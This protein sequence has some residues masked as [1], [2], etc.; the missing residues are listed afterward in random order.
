MPG[1]STAKGKA[2]RQTIADFIANSLA[3][4]LDQHPLFADWRAWCLGVFPQYFK[5]NFG[6]RHNEFWAH[7]ELIG[8]VPD[9]PAVVALW[10][11][12][13][14]KSTT[15]EGAVIRIGSKRARRY[16]WYVSGTQDQADKHVSTISGMLEAKTVELYYP[17]LSKRLLDKYG[18]SEGWARNILRCSTGFTVE[19][20]GLDKAVRGG[21]IDWARPDLIIFDDVDGRHDTAK[22]VEKK[23]QTITESILPAGSADVAVVFVQNLIHRDS[24]ASRLAGLG[25][26]PADFLLR[27]V[28]LGPYPAVDGLDTE[29]TPDG[30]RIIAGTPTW[31]GQSLATCE[32]QIND[33]GLGAFLREAQH[34]VDDPPGGIWDHV[35]F[36]RIDWAD[37]PPLIDGSVWVDPAVTNTDDS[38]RHAIQAD[39]LGV[40]GK[41]YRLYSWEA[42]TSPEDCIRRAILKA[43]ELKLDTVGVETDQGGDTWWSVYERVWGDLETND[44][45][46]QITR[47]TRK[48][49]FREAKAGAGHGSKVHRN[50]LMLADYE[51]GA[52]I[53]VR[54]TTR[55]LEKA[56]RRFPKSKPFDLVDAAY[57]GWH[58]LAVSGG[59][60][61]G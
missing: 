48:P 3:E 58:H 53:H 49:A 47:D 28:V 11:R 12:G 42:R 33:W 23:I 7:A 20:I 40:D 46:P 54:G 1:S 10:P 19:A 51:R 6:S 61:R 9:L 52:V 29:Q 37:L 32:K 45:Y 43:I 25:E 56:L 57:W 21:K 27:R 41:L 16:A 5:D 31:A 13:S 30:V 22:T 60:S 34:E 15:V 2:G 35:V 24:I 4:D 8:E 26:K 36:Q 18:Q 17:A 59:W 38:D 44:D 14:G 55:A 39:A 50:G